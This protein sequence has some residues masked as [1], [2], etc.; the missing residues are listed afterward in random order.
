MSL[1]VSQ[2]D[3]A[4]AAINSAGQSYQEGDFTFER[5]RLA[6]LLAARKIAVAEE[7]IA[8]NKVFRRVRFGTVGA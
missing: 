6:D 2:I 1:S 7:R 3:A 8:A 5:A 4:I